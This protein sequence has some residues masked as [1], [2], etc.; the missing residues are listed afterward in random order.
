MMISKFE[1]ISLVENGVVLSFKSSEPKEISFSDMDK[2]YISVNKAPQLY[3]FLYFVVS[4]I[5]IGFSFW[6][7]NFDI[8]LFLPLVLIIF[9]AVKLNDYI[10]YRMIIALKNDD[11]FEQQVPLKSKNEAIDF[12][13][14]IRKE[15]F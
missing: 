6:I 4:L 13:N 15:I 8:I 7:M 11:F 2:I 3:V 12:V 5:V 14:K 1:N 10:R 9:G